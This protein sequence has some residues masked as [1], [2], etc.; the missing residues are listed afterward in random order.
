MIDTLMPKLKVWEVDYSFIIKNYLDPKMWKET[1]TL[2]EYK[3]YVFTLK[4][5]SIDTEEKKVYFKVKSNKNFWRAET[6]AY[7]LDNMKVE[8]LKD[9]I[10]GAIFR[11]MENIE[12]DEIEHTSAYKYIANSSDEEEEFL[13]TIAE[14]FLDAN[15]VSNKDI[16]EVYIENYVSNHSTIGDRLSGLKQEMKY[17]LL[18][19]LF[20]VFTK[21]IKDETRIKAVEN[22]ITY[23]DNCAEILQ[24]V[25]EY[26]QYLETEEAKT[27]AENNL[28]NI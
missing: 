24:E 9:L 20:L 28:E 17:K 19:D 1:W 8:M 26:M 11:L 10:N 2:F 23:L 27:E 25:E 12:S 13:K 15:N 3:N 4:I 5:S 18:T 21:S 22:K 7:W 6:I 14:Q 16:R